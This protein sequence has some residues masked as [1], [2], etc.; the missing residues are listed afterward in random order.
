MLLPGTSE[1][2]NS[3][4]PASFPKAT[5]SELTFPLNFVI[6]V[7]KLLKTQ[8]SDA[9][10]SSHIVHLFRESALSRSQKILLHSKM[11]QLYSLSHIIDHDKVTTCPSE[12]S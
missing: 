12:A 8:I 5:R 2:N 3:P 10:F 1:D 7:S 11:C 4:R 9:D 6:C